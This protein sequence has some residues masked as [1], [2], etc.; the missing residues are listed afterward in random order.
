M[1][2]QNI[3]A[4]KRKKLAERIMLV[5]TGN[6]M[7]PCYT[8]VDTGEGQTPDDLPGTI[9]SLPTSNKPPNKTRIPFVQGR[10][11]M[12]GT[13]VLRFCG[14]HNYQL[15]IS[16]RDPRLLKSGSN[17]KDSL[18]GFTIIRRKDP[19]QTSES[20]IYEYLAQ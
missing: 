1:I 6:S 18:W 2:G 19:S 8:I 11:N 13:G 20:S 3:D 10:F 17:E 12:G 14:Y 5:A 9:L 15:V 7:D 4:T 16:R